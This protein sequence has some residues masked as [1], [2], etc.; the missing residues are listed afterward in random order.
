[1]V[2]ATTFFLHGRLKG[3]LK[4]QLSNELQQFLWIKMPAPAFYLGNTLFALFR[5]IAI[6]T[7]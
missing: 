4:S 1:M 3:G 2:S 5:I 7:S 6:K